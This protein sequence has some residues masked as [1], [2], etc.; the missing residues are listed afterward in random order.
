M[1]LLI[2][3]LENT[4]NTCMMHVMLIKHAACMHDACVCVYIM[5][6]CVRASGQFNT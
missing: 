6:V 3:L 5:C 2:E 4:D 1:I